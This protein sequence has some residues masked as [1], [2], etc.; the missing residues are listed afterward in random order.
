[1]PHVETGRAVSPGRRKTGMGPGPKLA[2]VVLLA[3]VL[4]ASA[5]MYKWV[6]EKGVTHFSET[7]PPDGKAATKIEPRPTPPSGP[8][9]RPAE[10]WQE[11]D[12]DFRKRRLEKDQAEEKARDASERSA[13]NRK[14][15]CLR[16]QRNLHQLGLGIPLYVINE[17]GEQVWMTDEERARNQADWKRVA[18]ENCDR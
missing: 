17:K 9:T 18:E 2:F 15:N 11:K 4:P 14:N 13:A 3:A 1:M 8:A 12:M 6:D 16:A 7:P 5:A 10:N